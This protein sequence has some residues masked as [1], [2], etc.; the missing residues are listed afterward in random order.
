MFFS[1]LTGSSDSISFSHWRVIN[2]SGNDNRLILQYRLL[3]RLPY[4][5]VWLVVKMLLDYSSAIL[6]VPLADLLSVHSVRWSWLTI[7]EFS[8]PWTDLAPAGFRTHSPLQTQ[9]SCAYNCLHLRQSSMGL[10]SSNREAN[11]SWLA[12]AVTVVNGTTEKYKAFL[13]G[14]STVVI[15]GRPTVHEY[16]CEQLSLK[17]KNPYP[18][19]FFFFPS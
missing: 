5:T 11:C 2:K 4:A 7:Q 6:L 14:A 18:F 17:D 15:N 1:R 9:W 8:G 13:F 3:A 10:Q 12:K 16:A 19:E